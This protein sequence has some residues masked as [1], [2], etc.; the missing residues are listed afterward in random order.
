MMSPLRW[1]DSYFPNFPRDR[2]DGVALGFLC[3]MAPL[4]AAFELLFIIPNVYHDNPLNHSLHVVFIFWV[5]SNIF[6]NLFYILKTNVS[7]FDRVLPAVLKPGWKFCSSCGTNSPPRSYHCFHCN[8][9][10]LKRDHHCVFTGG[11]V[12][13]HNHRY[14]LGLIF[15]LW[16]GTLYANVMN[17][18]FVWEELGALGVKAIISIV[19]PLV[20]WMMG[21]VPHFSFLVALITAI[22]GISFVWLTA[23]LFFHAKLIRYNQ[24]THEKNSGTRQYDL[25]RKANLETVLGS[26]WAISW[27][28]PLIP[29]PLLGDGLEFPS[30]DFI[31]MRDS[32][33]GI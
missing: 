5:W 19:L 26:R 32:A 23:L 28:S 13:F 6:L 31:G 2:S 9:C 14:Y 4:V 29:S 17:F 12:G 22:V 7:T 11:C 8:K 24:T 15:Y 30:R 16:I 10:I 20:S 27:I 33:K 25:G 18:D 21:L 3:L 1:C